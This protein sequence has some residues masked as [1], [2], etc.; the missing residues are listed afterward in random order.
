MHK[1]CRTVFAYT[2]YSIH[3]ANGQISKTHFDNT[4]KDGRVLDKDLRNINL[5]RLIMRPVFVEPPRLVV[6]MSLVIQ[7]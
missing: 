3:F 6:F 7:E 5:P 1:L 2:T 4:D